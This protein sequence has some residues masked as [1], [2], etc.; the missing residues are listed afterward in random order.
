MRSAVPNAFVIT[1]IVA[2]TLCAH[3]ASGSTRAEK[4][5]ILPRMHRVE[6]ESESESEGG[7][8]CSVAWILYMPTKRTRN[9]FSLRGAPRAHHVG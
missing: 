3:P 5:R 9:D 1:N 8:T 6:S 2:Y 4:T 7:S